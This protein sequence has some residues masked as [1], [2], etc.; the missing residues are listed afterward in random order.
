MVNTQR[1]TAGFPAPAWSVPTW[2]DGEGNS[3]PEP[4]ELADYTGK[5]LVILAFQSWCPGCHSSGFPTLQFLHSEFESDPNVEFLA[6]QTVFEGKETNTV[7]KLL[8]YQQKYGLN[9]P[10]GHDLGDP[11]TGN[12]PSIMYNYRTGG[13]P[14]ILVI[15]KKG[16]VQFSDFHIDPNGATELI[17]LLVAE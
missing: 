6:V 4:V 9:I 7:D 13:T 1:G 17:R 5:V 16:V 12:Y 3:L 11:S 15:D 14:W 2:I 8:E 10:F